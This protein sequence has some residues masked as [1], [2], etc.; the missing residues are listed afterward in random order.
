MKYENIDANEILKEKIAK[1]AKKDA[2][3]GLY[4]DALYIF[5]KTLYEDTEIMPIILI[6]E[7]DIPIESAYLNEDKDPSY[8]DNMIDFM[9]A[10]LTAAL[11]GS[12]TFFS[13]AVLTGVYRIAKESIFSGLNNLAVY[14]VF[15]EGMDGKY[16][17]TEDEV[18]EMLRY[19][20]LANEDKEI[21]NTWL[22]TSLVKHTTF[23]IHGVCTSGFGKE[24]RNPC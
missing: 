19:Y 16:G 8:Y 22:G 1:I 18:N 7:Y 2:D 5:S 15:N 11:K 14:T 24:G 23:T 20:I 10:F 9:R 17:F 13:F 21:I 6:D 4:K 3:I 12:D